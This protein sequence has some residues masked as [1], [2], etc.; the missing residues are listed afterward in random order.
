[1]PIALTA[2]AASR[3]LAAAGSAPSVLN[4]Q[5]WRF[6]VRR[7]DVIDVLADRYRWLRMRDPQGR[8]LHISCGAAVFNLRIAAQAMGYEPA[9]RLLP[10]PK[11]APELLA[12]VTLAPPAPAPAPASISA[13]ASAPA[14]APELTATSAAAATPAPGQAPAS[15]SASPAEEARRL[16]D[17]IRVRRTYRGPFADRVIPEPVR[18]ELCT[19]AVL[20]GARLS[21]LSGRAAV[22]LLGHVAVAQAELDRDEEYQAELAAWDPSSYVPDVDPVRDFGCQVG[23]ARFE[24][25]PQLA[26][27]TAAADEPV[28]WLQAGQA[29]QRMLLVAAGHRISVSYLNQPLDLRDMRGRRNP[30][31]RSGHPQMIMRLGYGG[32]APR[33]HRRPMTE[34]IAE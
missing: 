28:D 2:V 4:T 24:P 6:T 9:V 5:P 34:L 12:R 32:I 17:L 19:A 1:M 23:Y 21:F 7:P 14:A 29:L 33:A 26:V 31:H 20:E 18:A 11:S 15:T 13:P 10:D 30:R 3:L 16:Y 27:L 8:W 25:R 22:D